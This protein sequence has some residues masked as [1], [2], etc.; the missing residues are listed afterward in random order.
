MTNLQA[1]NCNFRV[2]L[3]TVEILNDKGD[4]GAALEKSEQLLLCPEITKKQKI[5]LYTWQFLIHRNMLKERKA[6]EALMS[7]RA[8]RIE[9]NI[10]PDFKFKMYLAESSALRPDTLFYN[11]LLSEIEDRIFDTIQV[12]DHLSLGRYYFLINYK[13]D[14]SYPN[15]IKAL[16]HFDQLD[17]IPVFHKGLTLRALGNKSRDRGDFEKSKEYYA[18]ELKIYREKYPDKHFN[19]SICNY[20]L[21]NVHYEMLEYELALQ[22]YLLVV[23]IWSEIYPPEH[24]LM[25]S[26]N[27]AIG[28]MYWELDDFENALDFFNAS[29]VH[30]QEVNNDISENT[31]KK[32]DSA[33]NDGNYNNALD[34]YKEALAWREKIYGKGHS[35]T[36]ACQ[37]FVGRAIRASGDTMEALKTY[38]DA[39]AKLVP[40][41]DGTDI[42]S[43]P[44]TSMKI[45]SH[46]YLLES[47]MA[48]G[49]LLKDWYSQ[50]F[51]EKNLMAALETQETALEVLEAMKQGHMS[52]ASQLF[53]TQRTLNLVE[54]SIDT[55]VKLF[56][57]KNDKEYLEKAFIFSERSKALLLLAT[58][59]DYQNASFANVPN[60]LIVKE[61]ELQ[62]SITE[63]MGKLESE[64]KR[65][66][67]V[68]N[69]MLSLYNNKLDKLKGEYDLL[70][71]TIKT[72]YPEFYQLKF[73]PEVES[74]EKIQEGLAEES[75]GLVSYFMGENLGFVFLITSEKVQIRKIENVM[76]LVNTVEDLIQ[77]VHGKIRIQKSPQ[78]QYESFVAYSKA[79][80]EDLLSS[81]LKDG[82]FKKLVVVPDGILSYLP[83]ELLLEKSV[84]T[85]ERDYK[86]LPYLLK[87]YAVS[88]SPSASIYSKSQVNGTK[89][90]QY[91][92]FAP[93]Y[94]NGGSNSTRE[95]L[96]NLQFNSSEV[97]FAANLFNG[98]S[99]IGSNVSEEILKANSTKAGIIHLA[100]H[101]EVEDEH[102]LL[103]KLYFNPSQ[104]EDGILHT[105]EIY[106][107]NINSQLVILS[108]CNTASGKLE[109]GEGILSLERAFQYAGSRSL[110]ST[111]WAVDDAA[112]ADLTQTFLV[113]LKEGQTKDV[114]L[115]NAKINYLNTA[116]PE[117]LH[118]FYWSSFRLT[119]NTFKLESKSHQK[120][121]WAGLGL[122]ALLL[123]FFYFRSKKR[124]A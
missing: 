93:T 61:R 50:N 64:E 49:E 30:E 75:K 98:R 52:E 111:L 73:Q 104:K 48:K 60:E 44:N 100:M 56:E 9:E 99:F 78:E 10:P 12:K 113:N 16:Y 28:D 37:N 54:N 63:Y 92:G 79:L 71:N 29:V 106:N 11:N 23:P 40:E 74:L 82:N 103:S 110:L 84:K 35:L 47:L 81:E 117:K 77:E 115:Q 102:P 87:S 90:D 6:N 8:L 24:T 38:Q 122:A 114:A 1:Q 97:E 3:E 121:W 70:L 72:A 14:D 51:E 36:A 112:S 69:K 13:G 19:I 119:G 123:G 43:N 96:S 116:T 33:L 62:S 108:A 34:Y 58:F 4:F 59:D 22:N 101:G 2:E 88:Y 42:Y 95:N 26:L 76:N 20:N 120:L 57:L 5:E 32:A 68:R 109:R 15:L 124:A 65:C 118:P 66:A 55:A 27:E 31:I 41:V 67:Q 94:Q 91:L 21:G 25:R 18:R 86:S 53:W 105:Y 83:F 80:Y 46:Q 107:M 7:A 45:K 89:Q 39:I 85:N 17:S